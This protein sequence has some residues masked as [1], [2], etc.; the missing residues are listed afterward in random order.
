[1]AGFAQTEAPQLHSFTH[2]PRLSDA[3][4][5]IATLMAQT[6]GEGFVE[7][8]SDLISEDINEVLNWLNDNRP[9]LG[10]ELYSQLA[11][12]PLLRVK[13]YL[14][15]GRTEWKESND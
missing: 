11:I 3:E 7:D 13:L 4:S 5:A 1:M 8:P 12:N 9:Q 6:R 14:R 2:S 10:E 15:L